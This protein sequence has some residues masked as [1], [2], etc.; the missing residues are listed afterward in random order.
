MRSGCRGA[1]SGHDVVRATSA[2]EIHHFRV[3]DRAG[4]SDVRPMTRRFDHPLTRAR[5]GL[6]ALLLLPLT[7]PLTGLMDAEVLFAGNAHVVLA[8]I[9]GFVALLAACVATRAAWQRYDVRTALVASGFTVISMLLLIHALATPGGPLFAGYVPIVQWA[10]VLSMPLGAVF[11]A[12]AMAIS[13]RQSSSR[14]KIVLIQ[15]SVLAACTAFGAATLTMP[16]LLPDYALMVPPVSYIVVAITTLVFGWAAL[17]AHRIADMTRRA[18]DASMF[19]GIVSLAVAVAVYVT[20]TPFD[21][22][23]WF[24][25]VFELVGFV[26]ITAGVVTDLRRPVSNWRLSQARDGRTLLASSEELLGG[27]VHALTVT[28]A[29]LD[30]STWHHSRRVA[31][32]AVEVG[33]ELELDAETI[34]RIAVAGLV[35]DIGKLHIPHD[36]LHKAGKLTDEEFDLIKAHPDFG[37]QLLGNLRGFDAELGIVLGHHEK[38][39]GR[40]Y[41]QGLKGDQ[42]DLETRIMTACD[43]YDA[44]TDSRSYKEPWPVERAIGLLREESGES[45]DPAVVEALERVVLRRASE[46]PAA[47]TDHDVVPIGSATPAARPIDAPGGLEQRDAA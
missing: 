22:Q 40:G 10:G 13:P 44:L 34:R 6:C 42:I 43:V 45:F 31:E 38:L 12:M 9:M 11:I 25:H 5:I 36:V 14:R 3:K 24:G 7:S 15:S 8:G 32:L 18:G 35:H 27:Y 41:P 26:C 46:A 28:L 33:E 4:S 39:S 37:F 21:R 23:F 17:R 16:D 2:P 29:Q 1:S 47:A 20:S 30:P 19:A